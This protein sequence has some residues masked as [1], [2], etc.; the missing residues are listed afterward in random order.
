MKVQGRHL[1]YTKS[2]VKAKTLPKMLRLFRQDEVWWEKLT[3]AGREGSLPGLWMRTEFFLCS[4]SQ[5]KSLSA[6]YF[7]LA[8]HM[9]GTLT[10]RAS[11]PPP[12]LDNLPQAASCPPPSPSSLCLTVTISLISADHIHP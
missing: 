3:L 11:L 6:L 9:L 2:V 5:I 1:V 7:L 12:C 8:S 4:E 10:L